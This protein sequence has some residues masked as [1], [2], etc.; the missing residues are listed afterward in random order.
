[1]ALSVESA[2]GL[3]DVKIITPCVFT[4]DRGFFLESFSERIYREA[5]IPGPFVQ[6]NHSRSRR[7]V[8]RGLHFQSPNSQGKLVC[9]A[10]GAVWDVAVDIRPGSPTFGRWVGEELSDASPRQLFIPAGF[11]HGFSVLSESADFI[12]KCTAYYS[13][14]DERTLLWSDPDLAIDWKVVDPI[15]SAKDRLGAR[16]A[17][18]R[19][20]G[21]NIEH[22]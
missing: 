21:L 22:F 7:G 4:D 14:A 19:G 13:S 17:E 10:R 6:D 3:P 15:V 18:I 2:P 5:G 1:V 16:L 11:A 12:Y 9:V 8:I 20:S